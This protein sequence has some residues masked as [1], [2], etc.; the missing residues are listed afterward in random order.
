ML[1]EQV[2]VAGMF[3]YNVVELPSTHSHQG[4]PALLSFPVFF[5][6]HLSLCELTVG[7]WLDDKR[8]REP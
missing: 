2:V 7:C 8:A 3:P 6:P 1:P 5:F 4:Q